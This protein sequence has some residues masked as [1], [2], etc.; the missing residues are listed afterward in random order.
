MGRLLDDFLREGGV[1]LPGSSTL[2]DFRPLV[3]VLAASA[4][5]RRLFTGSWVG[6]SSSGSGKRE[7]SRAAISKR[8]VEREW[9]GE[10][11]EREGVS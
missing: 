2:A 3:G 8:P 10:R 6:E 5:P 9:S 4:L 7:D 1:W 11:R